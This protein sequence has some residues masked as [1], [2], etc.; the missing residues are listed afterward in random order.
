MI[1]LVNNSNT[2]KKYSYIN[3]LHEALTH[4]CIDYYE[5]D[6]ITDEILSMKGKIKGIILSGSYLK[7]SENL[8]FSKFANDIRCMIQLDVPVLGICFGCQ[9]LTVL[10]GGTLSNRRTFFCKTVEIEKKGFHPLLSHL[11]DKHVQFCYSDLPII[12]KDSSIKVLATFHKYGKTYGCAF[13][14]QKNR[15]YGTLFHP[16][17]YQHSYCIFSNFVKICDNYWK[18]NNNI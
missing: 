15:F 4:L 3:K 1:L 5:T 12:P 10:F 13:E 18:I 8:L 2:N 14:F 6:S 7:L 9:L 11:R 16:E 17:Y